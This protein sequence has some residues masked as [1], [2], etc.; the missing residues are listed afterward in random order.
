MISMDYGGVDKRKTKN[1]LKKKRRNR[2]YKRGGQF[3]TMEPSYVSNETEEK[4]GKKGKKK[5]KKF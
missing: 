5:Q 2:V 1:D 3:R 4:K